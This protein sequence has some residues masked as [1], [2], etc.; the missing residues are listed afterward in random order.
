V[1][2]EDALRRFAA[3]EHIPPSGK[4]A[5]DVLATA[6]E[7]IRLR[8]IRL[9]AVA[10]V[11]TA[12]VVVGVAVALPRRDTTA[13]PTHP[14]PT[15]SLPTVEAKSP[16]G[17]PME[18][19]AAELPAPPGLDARQR[20]V[21]GM[22]P[23]GRYIVGQYRTAQNTVG[24]L[25]W[26]DGVLH[27]P[28]GAKAFAARAVNT[29]GVVAGKAPDGEASQAAVFRDGKVT[30]LPRPPGAT[31]S[32]VK[33]INTRGD[34]V[35][36]VSGNDL[37]RFH[38]SA[39]DLAILWPA[40]GGY[41]MLKTDQDDTWPHEATA[42]D[43]DGVIYGNLLIHRQFG[44]TGY[45]GDR[46][47]RWN[48]DGTGAMLPLPSLQIDEVANLVAATGS[49]AI[50]A[51]GNLPQ[52]EFTPSPGTLKRPRNLRW[53]LATGTF[54]TLSLG[55]PLDVSATG[56]VVGLGS[57]DDPKPAVWRAGTETPLPLLDPDRSLMINAS[58]SADGRTI[59][60]STMPPD[61]PDLKG[62]YDLIRWS[63]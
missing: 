30:I 2:D 7:T 54:E 22:D 11:A 32:S 44:D 60:G 9:A 10:G 61:S 56:V 36:S 53:N 39:E 63:C 48:A 51:A 27:Q 59:V 45:S 37:P 62:P 23:S 47:Y 49:W 43:D 12:L 41:V 34:I 26:T 33:A 15:H 58:I 40:T 24:L 6:R 57:Q 52:G 20:A 17:P 31:G 14:L 13:V 42:I 28:A 21:I 50:G 16:A 46:P 4:R 5:E 25:L 55:M 35:G 8:R 1:I 38:D 29:R 18:C 19:R 3:H